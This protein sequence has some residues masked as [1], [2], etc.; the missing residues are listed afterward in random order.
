MSLS[1]FFFLSPLDAEINMDPLREIKDLKV[2]SEGV[3]GAQGKK[4]KNREAQVLVTTKILLNIKGSRE[5]G[6]SHL[7]G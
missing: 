3:K 1:L 5:L 6:I 4:D 2:M 7:E